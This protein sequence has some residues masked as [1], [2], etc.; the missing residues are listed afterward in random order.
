M[1]I[2]KTVL[3]KLF[4]KNSYFSFVLYND[5]NIWNYFF[6]LLL[7]ILILF[8]YNIIINNLI[9]IN[10]FNKKH[11]LFVNKNRAIT[12]ILLKL[13]VKNNALKFFKKIIFLMLV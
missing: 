8:L 4:E 10:I 3:T 7:F 6:Y 2:K 12:E 5:N 13:N 9:K 1:S 11:L